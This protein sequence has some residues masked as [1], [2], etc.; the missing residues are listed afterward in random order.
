MTAPEAWAPRTRASRG[1]FRWVALQS[2]PC[3]RHLPY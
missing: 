1:A 3:S 2:S